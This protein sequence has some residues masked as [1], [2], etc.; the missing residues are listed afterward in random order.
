[1]PDWLAY[2]RKRCEFQPSSTLALSAFPFFLHSN[3]CKPAAFLFLSSFLSILLSFPPTS[4]SLLSFLHVL[5]F[6]LPYKIK[7]LNQCQ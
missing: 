2:F 4:F 1:M 3:P 7:G 5:H 6:P